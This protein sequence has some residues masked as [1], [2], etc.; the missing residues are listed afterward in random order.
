MIFTSCKKDKFTTAPQIK[1]KSLSHNAVD[2]NPNSAVPIVTL[3]ITDAEGDLGVNGND[4]AW[5]YMKTFLPIH[6]T[7]AIP[8]SANSG[9]KIF[10]A[11]IDITIDK[12]LKCKSQPG[13]V[14]HTDTLYSGILR[15]RFR[16]KQKQ[17]SH[18][19]RRGLF[20]L[21]MKWLHFILSHSIFVAV[22]AAGWYYKPANC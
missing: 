18:H 16:Q 21:S 19:Y 12:V 2:L 11:D 20:H 13:N 15:N 9:Q 4:I 8:R 14:L 6:S 10:E 22:C 5:V 1:Y 3:H 7:P 17:C